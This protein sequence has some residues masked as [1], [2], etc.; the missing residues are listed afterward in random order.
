[1]RGHHDLGSSAIESLHDRVAWLPDPVPLLPST[2]QS[3]DLNP[4]SHEAAGSDMNDQQSHPELDATASDPEDADAES[5]PES[6]TTDESATSDDAAASTEESTDEIADTVADRDPEAVAADIADLRATVDD[7]ESQLEDREERIDELESALKHTKADY[8]NYK[9]RAQREKERYRER[10]TRDL[11]ERLLDVRDNLQRALDHGDDLEAGLE[12]TLRQFD[13]VFENEGVERVDPDPGAEIDPE[14][15]EV[16]ATIDADEPADTV[17]EVHR[18]GYVM[19][20]TVLRPAQIAASQ[21]S[22]D[23][24]G[25]DTTTED[26]DTG[27]DDPANATDEETTD[28]DASTDDTNDSSDEN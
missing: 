27:T 1:M 7:L 2:C 21:G 13:R 3:D 16:L 8:Q 9:K 10:A 19:A 22:E 24:D 15:H 28:T 14:R 11:V 23:D 26:G 25:E 12:S 20:G 4:F 6:D 5:A 18:A 17:A